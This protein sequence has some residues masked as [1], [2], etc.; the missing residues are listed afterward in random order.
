[1]PGKKLQHGTGACKIRV[2]NGRE[3]QRW[4]ALQRVNLR[5]VAKA[6]DVSEA[7][8]SRVL[9]P[10]AGRVPISPVTQERV[11]R[12]AA[13]LGY[14]P[15]TL[16]RSLSRSHTDTLGIVLPFDAASLAKSYISMILA[17][18]GQ[19]ASAHGLALALYYA[20]PEHR[21]NYAQVMRDGRVD[22]GIVIDGT[23]MSEEQI[24]G[25]ETD[26]FPV[27]VTGHRLIGRRV[28][29]VSADDYG[30]SVKLT[31]YLLQL[32]HQRIVHIREP[33]SQPTAERCRGFVDAMTEAGLYEIQT[34]VTVDTHGDGPIDIDH[35]ALVSELLSRPLR[36]TAIFAWND[37]VASS[38]LLSA[39]RQGIRVPEQLSIAGYNDFPIAQLTNPPLT[40]IRQPLFVMGQ[41]AVELLLQRIRRSS[42]L[43]SEETLPQRVVSPELVIRESCAPPTSASSRRDDFE[44]A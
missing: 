24:A 36:P 39:V 35:G 17:G 40:T 6:A 1:M 25:L 34:S 9:H 12:A 33:F 3:R 29:F 38:M 10:R 7:T 31:R 16:A 22:G 15:N 2:M 37:I 11:R 44:L 28:S 43:A 18:V 41:L 42:S 8:A 26:P 20:D 19:S 4:D 21:A 23:S 13:D 5:D 27:V 32:G 30:A 14:R